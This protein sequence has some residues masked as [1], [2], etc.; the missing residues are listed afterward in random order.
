MIITQGNYILEDDEKK[1]QLFYSHQF[2]CA[3]KF[4][5]YNEKTILL[6]SL[7]FQKER[8]PMKNHFF[9]MLAYLIV[10]TFLFQPIQ[11]L[12]NSSQVE[13][14]DNSSMV[15]AQTP[16]PG[17]PYGEQF[18]K[19]FEMELEAERQRILE[20]HFKEE[21]IPVE[22]LS[23]EYG[24]DPKEKP[25]Y[26]PP[27]DEVIAQTKAQ[28]D[29][30][31][32]DSVTD[33]PPIE[34]EALVALYQSTNG[35]GWAHNDNWLI[36]N[37]VENWYGITISSGHIDEIAFWYNNLNGSIPA[38]LGNLSNLAYLNLGSNQLSGSIPAELGNLSN[39]EYLDLDGNQLSGS[40]PAELGNL[41]NLDHLDLNDNQLSGSI[42]AELGNLSNLITLWLD[43]NQLS[44][45]I[46][47]E[48]GNLGMLHYLWLNGNQLS[49]GIPP[50]LSN[51]SNLMSLHLDNNQLSGRIPQ[52]M[53]N[54]NNL[55]VLGM[56]DNK[57]SGSIPPVLGNLSNLYRLRLDN[58]QL[59]GS[60][61]PE[62][63]NLSHLE[64]I[65]LGGNQLSGSIP[66]E[67]ANLSNLEVIYLGS[68][69]L[70][71]NIPPELG[72]LSFLNYLYLE[73]N[74][75]SGNIPP[76]LGNLSNLGYLYLDSNQLSGRIP[77]VLGNLSNLYRLRLDNN[78]LSGNIPPELG[79]LNNLWY[80]YLDSNQLSGSIP[81][82]L[83]N[84]SN[85]R[86]LDLSD[87]Q[88]S[89]NIPPELG[90]LTNLIVLDLSENQLSGN[91]P[92]SFINLDYLSVFY[93]YDT[94]L[95]EPDT[96]EFLAWKETVYDWVGSGIICGPYK[97]KYLVVPLNWQGTQ[98]EFESAASLQLN[99]FISQ[100]PLNSCPEKILIRYLDV[101]TYNYNGFT[102]SKSDLNDIRNFVK[103][104]VKINPSEW[105][106]VIGFTETSPCPPTA[107]KSNTTDT[108]WV[109][110]S[111]DIIVAHELGHIYDLSD[112]YCSNQAGSNDPRCN[113]GDNQG[114]GWLTGDINFLDATLPYDC[115]P[116]GSE[117]QGGAKC[118]NYSLLSLCLFK[119][120]GV[121]CRGNKNSA[122][123]RSTMSYANAP[124]PRGFDN[125]ELEYL[126]SKPELNCSDN[127]FAN[128]QTALLIPGEI[129][130]FVLNVSLNISS[131]DLVEEETITVSRGRPTATS[132]L[133]GLSGDYTLQIF[134]SSHNE[135]L[136]Q[137]FS[138]YFDYM[139]PVFEDV[140]YSGITYSSQDVSFRFPFSNAMETLNLYHNDELI[141][142]KDLPKLSLIYLPLI[143][144]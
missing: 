125:R 102:C 10:L 70:S 56:S 72:N 29:S 43:G 73:S 110:D 99:E 83:G 47:P 140:D 122:G 44:G 35:A 84:L 68:N 45:G 137:S 101:N 94:L 13:I 134:D 1:N 53:G 59:N 14:S 118:C 87:N 34:C 104:E 97:Q 114:D 38:E 6:F 41:S 24:S 32:C 7:V 69:Q 106:V 139:G 48:L 91:I 39:L 76:E 58:N 128:H 144:R 28:V 15:A 17:E 66:P 23:H 138:L 124:G 135:L 96:P 143:D 36:T 82:E 37:T 50:E 11:T 112:Q 103:N 30:F 98:Q 60:I 89:G 131:D 25:E 5:V 62:L 141:Y 20:E 121:C 120:Y 100:V 111:S 27:S 75:L 132:V 54:L 19:E 74:Q 4:F 61:P 133:E 93:F 65:Y 130:G 88:L 31:S 85:L 126:S 79:N 115:P 77:A 129:I 108:I 26:I 8:I 2:L 109:S 22:L 18:E 16:I 33:V 57:L 107:G 80:L 46:P 105:D 86:D 90:N 119:N 123:G 9:R 49:G 142:T 21:G 64:N 116:D 117:D 78:Q 136:S 71:G 95:C 81:L 127:Q 12:A 52:G 92:L 63:G 113:D 55:Q 67:L 40:I 42:P 3:I 51:L